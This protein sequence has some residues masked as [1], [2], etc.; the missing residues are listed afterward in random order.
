MA[1]PYWPL[2]DLRIRTERVELRPPTDDDL[3]ELAAVAAR[4]I[5]DPAEM[6]FGAPWTDVPS[7][8]LERNSLQHYGGARAGF[9]AMDWHLPLAVSHEGRLVGTQSILATDFPQLRT[10][11]TGSW[12][13][14][15]FQGQGIGKEMRAAAL[16]LV[17]AGL[18]GEVATS[19]AWHDNGASIGV[20]RALGYEDNGVLTKLRRGVPTRQIQ[21]RLERPAWEQQRPDRATIEGLDA[22]LALFGVVEDHGSA[23][24]DVQ[25][26][27]GPK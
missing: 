18:G 15:Q 25:R 2:F 9:T 26:F 11:S 6:P 3:V 4:G 20:S 7:P 13:G 8:Q 12:L 14:R 1:H 21:F 19:A 17:F 27:R 24:N 22:C 5:H 23:S 16:Y 10:A